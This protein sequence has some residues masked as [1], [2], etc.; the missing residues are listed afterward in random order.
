M[1]SVSVAVAACE[2]GRSTR[3]STRP[4]VCF[5]RASERV[6]LSSPLLLA[7]AVFLDPDERSI[8]VCSCIEMTFIFQAF[9]KEDKVR[10]SK[11]RRIET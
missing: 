4:R 5:E 10:S 8:G 11:L 7:R 1:L 2:R 9:E 3:C 6:F